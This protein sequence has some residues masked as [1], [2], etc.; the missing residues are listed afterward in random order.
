MLHDMLQL[1]EENFHLL[2]LED[3]T[4]DVILGRLWLVQHN[5]IIFWRTGEVLK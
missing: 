2:V 3:S 5:P 4:T 1:H